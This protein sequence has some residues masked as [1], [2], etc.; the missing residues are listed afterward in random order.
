MKVDQVKVDALAAS[1]AKK[2][3][4]PLRWAQERATIELYGPDWQG[5]L[6]PASKPPKSGL[7]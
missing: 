1:I 6:D 7:V 4:I 2:E 3:G 5:E